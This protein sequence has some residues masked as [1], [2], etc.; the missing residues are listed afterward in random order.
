[1]KTYVKLLVLVWF[2]LF[3]AHPVRSQSVKKPVQQENNAATPLPPAVTI[4][5]NTQDMSCWNRSGKFVGSRLLPSRVLISGDGLRRAMVEVEAIGYQPKDPATYSGSLCENHSRLFFAGPQDKSLKVVYQLSP[6]FS[7]G[8]SLK[9][10]DWS[11][12][13]TRLLAERGQ[14]EYESEGEYTD[15]VVFDSRTGSTVEPNIEV[16]LE[17]R[18]G[19]G[20]SSDNSISGFT[21]NG[22]VV[23]IVSPISEPV[24]VM[25]GAKSCV[26]RKTLVAVST[27]NGRTPA[28]ELLPKSFKLSYYGKFEDTTAAKQ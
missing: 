14:W 17:A 22:G 6:D 2:A 9:L 8:N 15:F 25:N 20:C 1:M 10:V 21:P 28:I 4:S 16:A 26:S 13:G 18:F 11:P 7:E 19:K 3:A 5:N 12:D 27:Q 24:A 23:V